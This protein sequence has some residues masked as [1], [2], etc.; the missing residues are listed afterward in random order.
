MRKREKGINVKPKLFAGMVFFYAALLLTLFVLPMLMA[1]HGGIGRADTASWDRF[2]DIPGGGGTR[3]DKTQADVRTPRT[4]APGYGSAQR[5]P[6]DK[7]FPDAGMIN[8]PA[9]KM[10]S[11]AVKA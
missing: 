3:A 6:L 4:D 11:K 5:T 9:N 2:L 10:R 1:A 8:K 7:T